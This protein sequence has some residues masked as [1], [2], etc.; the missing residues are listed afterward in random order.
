MS[1]TIKSKYAR[2][3]VYPHG[4]TRTINDQCCESKNPRCAEET[5]LANEMESKLV[6]L[7]NQLESIDWESMPLGTERAG[8][9]A[10]KALVGVENKITESGKRAVVHYCH[11]WW[12]KHDPRGAGRFASIFTETDAAV[13]LGDEAMVKANREKEEQA[14][15]AQAITTASGG[16]GWLPTP[17]PRSKK[18]LIIGAL[19]LLSGAGLTLY[20]YLR[21]SRR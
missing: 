20:M 1:G 10:M 4:G 16:P 5:R 2:L 3:G 9:K 12:L 15:A 14:V 11:W 13:K 17:E 19:I 8:K 18:P 21:S 7:R 6:G